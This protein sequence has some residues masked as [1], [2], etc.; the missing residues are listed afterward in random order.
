MVAAADGVVSW[1]GMGLGLLVAIAMASAGGFVG[2]LSRAQPA[3][4]MRIGL[5]L[6]NTPI[7]DMTGPDPA[8]RNVCA[9][10]SGL[11]D[12]GLVVGRDIAIEPR[13]AQGRPERGP[14]LLKELSDLK[15]DV[16]VTTGGPV[17]RAGKSLAFGEIDI[18]GADDGK[19]ACR[20]TVT[21]ALL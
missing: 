2:R 4:K 20:A 5:L 13:S 3:V 7:A 1:I 18:R 17:L 14:E 6:N 12:L 11:R 19:S 8:D 10:V 9:F 16:I 15:V 21:Y